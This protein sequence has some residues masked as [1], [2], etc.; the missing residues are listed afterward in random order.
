[1]IE[2]SGKISVIMSVFNSE[3]YLKD[4]IESILCQTYSNFEFII[5]DDGST[6]K[7]IDILNSFRDKD[8]RI[9]LIKNLKNLGLTKNLNIMISLAKGDYIARMDSDD[10]S[11]PQRFEKQLIFLENHKT[12]GVCGTYSCVFGKHIKEKIMRFPEKHEDIRSNLL[13]ENV[14]VHSSVMLRK[15]IIDDYNIRYNEDF[16]IIQDYELWS[17]LKDFTEFANIPETLLRYRMSDSNICN[18]SEKRN[19]YRNSFIHKIHSSQLNK[20]GFNPCDKEIDLHYIISTAKTN[21]EYKNLIEGENW[22]KY[23]HKINEE[24][25]IYDKN[26]FNRMLGQYWFRICTKSSSLGFKSVIKYYKSDL[27]RYNGTDF[28]HIIKFILKCLIKFRQEV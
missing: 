20:F 16:S 7:S 24:K 21:S 2:G 9:L 4:S 23:L 11:L 5:T 12:I 19:D 18:T 27:N 8:K 1:M 3:E 13:F 22:L 28:F 10:I 15:K 14:I 26:S 17:R 25:N 6:D